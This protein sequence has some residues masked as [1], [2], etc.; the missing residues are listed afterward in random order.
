MTVQY[1]FIF[2][3]NDMFRFFK[4]CQKA[5]ISISIEL[6]SRRTACILD[7]ADHKDHHIFM[8]IFTNEW[9]CLTVCINITFLTFNL[10]YTY[11]YL[12]RMVNEEINYIDN[13]QLGIYCQSIIIHSGPYQ[14]RAFWN[15]YFEITMAFVYRCHIFR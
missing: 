8:D 7:T 14:S 5:Y 3:S 1:F 13:F 11:D 12:L 4:L 2:F 15:A 10:S 6:Y 9:P